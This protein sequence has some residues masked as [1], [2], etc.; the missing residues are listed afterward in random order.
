MRNSLFKYSILLFFFLMFLGTHAV[1]Q[2]MNLDDAAKIEFKSPKDYDNFE[3]QILEFIDWLNRQ[4][5]NHPDRKKV[6]AL[7]F[8]WAEGTSNVTISI[9]PFILDYADKN[10][11]F[12]TLYISGW[13]KFALNNPEKK[14]NEPL[15]TS[16]SPGKETAP[17]EESDI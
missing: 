1:A 14:D 15:E 8:K 7:I 13:I 6:N 16:A 11:G 2:I 12:L 17:M 5:L 10:P 3:D 9:M 4:P